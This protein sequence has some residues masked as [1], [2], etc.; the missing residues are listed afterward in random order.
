MQDWAMQDPA[1]SAVACKTMHGDIEVTS[2][3]IKM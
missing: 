1:I 2:K 3:R